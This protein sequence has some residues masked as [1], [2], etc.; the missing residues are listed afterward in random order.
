LAGKVLH[1]FNLFLTEGT[2]LATVNGDSADIVVFSKHRHR[3]QCADTSKID[4]TPRQW[5]A[6]AVARVFL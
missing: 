1:K 3:Y 6:R 5:F 4:R 2:N